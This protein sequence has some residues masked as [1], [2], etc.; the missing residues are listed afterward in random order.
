MKN[1]YRKQKVISGK[2]F[3]DEGKHFTEKLA[4]MCEQFKKSNWHSKPLTDLKSR[5]ISK[6][7]GRMPI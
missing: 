7:S 5:K 1:P 6:S 4:Y 2:P 3:S